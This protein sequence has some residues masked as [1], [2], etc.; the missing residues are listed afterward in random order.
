MEVNYDLPQEITSSRCYYL[1]NNSTI[2]SYPNSNTRVQWTRSG[3]KWY[4]TS[5]STSNYGYDYSSYNCLG[6]TSV[7]YEYSYVVPIYYFIAFI[8]SA[9]AF[10]LAYKLIIGRLFKGG[11]KW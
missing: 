10:Y 5:T 1:S 2:Y 6:N 11:S 8:V 7:E 3:S 9:M 4:K